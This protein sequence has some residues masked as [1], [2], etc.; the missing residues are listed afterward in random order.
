MHRTCLIPLFPLQRP[1]VASQHMNCLE[2]A[3]DPAAVPKLGEDEQPARSFM[4]NVPTRTAVSIMLHDVI[5]S[6]LARKCHLL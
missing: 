3:H 4:M 6:E 1:L 2:E 5:Y